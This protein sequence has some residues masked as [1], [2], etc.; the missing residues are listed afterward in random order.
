MELEVDVYACNGSVS[1]SGYSSLNKGMVYFGCEDQG[2]SIRGESSFLARG[3]A[4]NLGD[5]LKKDSGIDQIKFNF[6][7]SKTSVQESLD[8]YFGRP[9][10]ICGAKFLKPLPKRRRIALS[11]ELNKISTIKDNWGKEV[12]LIV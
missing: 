4:R 11:H 9:I 1:Q 8:G 12:R 5:S 7:D 10:V 3:V 6:P 2:L